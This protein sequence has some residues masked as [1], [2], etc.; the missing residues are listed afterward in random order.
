[1]LA[2]SFKSES[3][4]TK[5]ASDLSA[6]ETGETLDRWWQLKY[7]LPL[8]GE[9]IQFDDHIFEMG[10]W[11]S[12]G[13]YTC[14]SPARVRGWCESYRQHW[15]VIHLHLVTFVVGCGSGDHCL[16]FIW[17]NDSALWLV[18]FLVSALV[19]WWYCDFAWSCVWKVLLRM[20]NP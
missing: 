11:E 15:D 10:G 2:V 3:L 6:S 1:M 20:F 14:M 12:W 16:W 9:M 4:Q 8:L 18:R 19:I 5:I 7:L 17:H 13:R